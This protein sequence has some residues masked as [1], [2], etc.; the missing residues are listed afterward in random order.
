MILTGLTVLD[1]LR[2]DSRYIQIVRYDDFFPP[3]QGI[4]ALRSRLAPGE[5]V[6]SVGGVYP[7]GFLASYGV[8]EVFGY[9]GNQLRWYNALTR[10]EVR[11][12]AR[13]AEELQQYWLSFLSSAALRTLAARYVLLPGQV[14]LPGL[15]LLGADQR[16]AVYANEAAMP[17]AAV[18]PEAQVEPDSARRISILWSPTFDPSKTTIVEA[19]GAGHRSGRW[20]RHRDH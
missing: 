3:D 15:K 11:Q 13:S 20:D 16:V 1:L 10:Y 14:N 8:P 18:V 12:S 7:E 4:E 19:A 17:A 5:R 2:V 9:H 6:L